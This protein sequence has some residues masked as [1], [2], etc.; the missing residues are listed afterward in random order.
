MSQA[1]CA[2]KARLHLAKSK[3]KPELRLLKMLLEWGYEWDFFY[4]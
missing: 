3:K 4:E 2:E 1:A